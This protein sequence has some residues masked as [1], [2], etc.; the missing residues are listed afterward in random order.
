MEFREF[1]GLS[2]I[3]EI[4]Q[5]LAIEE[6]YREEEAIGHIS[7]II[8]LQEKI[9]IYEQFKQELQSKNQIVSLHSSTAYQTFY[10][11]ITRF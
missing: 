7:T 4:K 1:I 5:R 10:N 9:S 3:E 6:R 2:R 11:L 8:S